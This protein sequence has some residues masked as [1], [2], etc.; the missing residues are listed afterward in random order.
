MPN[1][2]KIDVRKGGNVN[3]TSFTWKNGH[4]NKTTAS[5][6]TAGYLTGTSY[7]V[8]G[9]SNGKDGEMSAGVVVG[10]SGDCNYSWGDKVTGTTG[11]GTLHVNNTS[12]RP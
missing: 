4:G 6:F 3:G 1:D 2:D 7:P 11:S 8:P 5:Q 9:S 10:V 12:P